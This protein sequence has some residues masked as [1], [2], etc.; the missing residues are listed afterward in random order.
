MV[1]TDSDD[2]PCGNFW[3]RAKRRLSLALPSSHEFTPLHLHAAALPRRSVSLRG[4]PDADAFPDTQ[5][6]T[7]ATLETH[8][9]G[10]TPPERDAHAVGETNPAT[11]A[12]SVAR[13]F[14]QPG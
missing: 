6:K 9:S 12:E 10:E 8:R 7:G 1:W 5:I 2:R 11:A 13:P 14:A 3:Q 4:N